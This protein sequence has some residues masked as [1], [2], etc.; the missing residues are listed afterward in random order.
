MSES[1]PEAPLASAGELE[2]MSEVGVAVGVGVGVATGKPSPTSR[3]GVGVGT[4]SVTSGRMGV[5]VGDGVGSELEG[6]VVP[7]PSFC[8]QVA[9][10]ETHGRH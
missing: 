7:A 5:A 4:W 1:Q 6:D 8:G 9:N 3:T 2:L 10:V